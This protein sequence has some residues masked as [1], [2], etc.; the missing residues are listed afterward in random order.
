MADTVDKYLCTPKEG[1]PHFTLLGRDPHAALAVEHWADQREQAIESG[2]YPESDR[3]KVA[4]AREKAA[5]MAEYAAQRK[6]AS[7]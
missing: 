3:E 7:A 2:E 5:I 4:E 1:E 6:S